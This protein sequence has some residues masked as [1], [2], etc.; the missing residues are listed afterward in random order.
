[1]NPSAIV[2]EVFERLPAIMAEH[3]VTPVGVLHVGAHHGE[4]QG[5]YVAAGF[6][7]IVWMEPNAE[8][9]QSLRERGLTVIEAAAGSV[10]GEATFYVTELSFWSSLLK[11]KS[12][13]HDTVTV[14]VVRIDSLD[15]G[16]N[17]LVVDAQ[18]SEPDVIASANLHDFDLAVIETG[19][20]Q[21]YEGQVSFEPIDAVME[22]TGFTL[23]GEFW[24]QHN[25]VICD[26]VYVR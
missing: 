2:T 16:C 23:V 9:A 25:K 6:Q 8:L 18:G 7:R 14:P 15:H 12:R 10:P 24:H 4:E 13:A 20:Q 26:R 3:N 19:T 21:E 5:A 1:M 22:A 11:P 17:V